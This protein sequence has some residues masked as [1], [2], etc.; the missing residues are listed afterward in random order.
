[1]PLQAFI[2]A[3][4]W[5]FVP[6]NAFPA[7]W[8]AQ[9][10]DLLA[11]TFC[12]VA[13]ILFPK[14]PISVLVF[15]VLAIF[16]KVTVML[17]PVYFGWNY[18]RFKKYEYMSAHILL[19]CFYFWFAWHGY[20]NNFARL[21][22]THDLAISPLTMVGVYLAHFLEAI[23]WQVFPVPFFSDLSGSLLWLGAG[24]LVLF[25]CKWKLN[26]KSSIEFAIMGVLLMLPAIV[27]PELRVVGFSTFFFVLAIIGCV[28]AVSNKKALFG[29]AL[30]LIGLTSTM[31]V[32]TQNKF[33]TL[34]SDPAQPMISGEGFYQ[35]SWYESKRAWVDQLFKY[36]A[37]MKDNF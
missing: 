35:N 14:R 20:L 27:N 13:L 28:Q 36:I 5:A 19:F 17:L 24:L 21:Y 16:S 4:V 31:I 2:A 7:T 26:Y 3:A 22:K 11:N 10:N 6:W 34:N 18:F 37:G 9:R 29:G 32:K 30:V 23:A 8:I 15:A 25:G 1:M 12:L 33:V